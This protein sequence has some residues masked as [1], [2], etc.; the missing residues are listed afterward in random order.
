MTDTQKLTFGPAVCT[1]P[2]C[3]F[4]GIRFSEM[5]LICLLDFIFSSIDAIE[6]IKWTG[7]GKT[8]LWNNHVLF[9]FGITFSETQSIIASV[10][11][12]AF[13]YPI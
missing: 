10:L 8:I 12:Q 6:F 13:L 9:D 3:I 11:I 5:G 4:F 1:T 7:L 2:L